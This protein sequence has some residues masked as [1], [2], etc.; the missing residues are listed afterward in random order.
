MLSFGGRIFIPGSVFL[1]IAV[2]ATF[3]QEPQ[4]KEPVLFNTKEADAIV[5]KMQIM[6]KDNPWNADVSKWPVAK[7]S[8]AMVASIGLDKPLRYNP[9]MSYVLVPSNQPRVDLQVVDYPD[10]SD[11]GPFPIP[12]NVPIE[13]WPANYKRD[14]KLNAL[15]GGE[16]LVDKPLNELLVLHHRTPARCDSE[17]HSSVRAL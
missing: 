2:A 10:E 8:D 1:L 14:D 6:P 15:V 5:S 9:D 12:P 7:N 11:K 4:L 13:G 16:L 17:R 3:A